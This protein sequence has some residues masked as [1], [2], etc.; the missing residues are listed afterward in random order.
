MNKKGEKVV[1]IYKLF[2]SVL[3]LMLM[4]IPGFIMRKT[5]LADD[6]LSKGF[7]NTILYITQPAMISVAFI[8]DFDKDILYIAVGVLIFS[9]VAHALFYFIALHLF[10]NAEKEIRKVL[11]FGVVFSN[12]G[13]M[14]IPLIIA[15][16]GDYAAIYASVY[17]IGFNVFSWSLGCLIYSEDKKYISPRKIFINAAS[18]PTYIGILVFVLPI[19]NYIP[20]VVV[21][22]LDMLKNTVAPMSMMLIGMRLAQVNFKGIFKDK[23]MPAGTVVRLII[24]PA[25]IWVIM[26]LVSLTGIYVSETAMTVVLICAATPCAAMT[27]MFAE[28]FNG[29]AIYA[30]K[31]VSITTL[32]SVATMPLVALLLKI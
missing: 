15:I 27:G 28:K 2:E 14:G 11:Q 16:L 24:F 8:R 12:A 32:L 5:G 31:F 17:I 9:F 20:L 19:N 26:R 29:D 18:I 7:A 23:Y 21:D 22:G 1:D 3:L 13:Y 10:K 6:G 30:S 25:L 4:I